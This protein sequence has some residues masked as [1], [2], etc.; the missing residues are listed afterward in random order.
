MV[1]F[2]NPVVLSSSLF[3][4]RENVEKM[5]PIQALNR[6]NINKRAS[7]G[8]VII[9]GG[10]NTTLVSKARSNPKALYPNIGGKN[11]ANH[12]KVDEMD[13]VFTE[14]STHNHI[15]MYDRQDTGINGNH[16]KVFCISRLNGQGFKEQDNEQFM[17]TIKVLGF[18]DRANDSNSKGLY[19]IVAYGIKTGLN[20]GNWTL[21]VGDRVMWHAMSEDELRINRGNGKAD[22]AGEVKLVLKPYVPDKNSITVRPIYRCLRRKLNGDQGFTKSY[23]ETVEGVMDSIRKV[24]VSVAYATVDKIDPRIDKKLF[25]RRMFEEISKES[26]W[27]AIEDAV[28]AGHAPIAKG[29]DHF[30]DPVSGSDLHKAQAEALDKLLLYIATHHDNFISRQMGIILSESK[31]QENYDI[32]IQK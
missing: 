4:E 26:N 24:S 13:I 8:L 5:H 19:P 17:Q 1:I 22:C 28:F 23:I 3:K 9:N 11:G 31:P 25:A 27:K 14:K 21:H 10:V 7:V 6:D 30:I 16:H 2:L 15:H 12:A 20:I 32:L 18:C 29:V